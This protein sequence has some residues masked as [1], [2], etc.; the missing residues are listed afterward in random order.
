MA[1][2]YCDKLVIIEGSQFSNFKDIQLH[3]TDGTLDIINEWAEEYPKEIEVLTTI[4]KF[5][6][7]RENQAANFNLALKRCKMGDYFLPFDADDLYFEKSIKKII[8]IT[9][10]GRVDYLKASGPN[11]AFSFDWYLI[12]NDIEYY[13]PQV[14]FKK[15]WRLNFT[16]THT[17][18]NYGK[19][20][21]FDKGG[22]WLN[23][24]KWVKPI[25]RMRLR[26]RTSG[27]FKGMFEWFENNWEKIELY[28]NNV[29]K[30][31]GGEFTLRKYN[32]P[33]P[34]ILDNH[35]WRYIKD[36]RKI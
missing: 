8:E 21:V 26:H 28:D 14:L 9:E 35:P 32:G 15:K 20:V 2:K 10:E 4:R 5:Q 22:D 17:P 13:Y 3:S 18:H 30:Y 34:K 29:V 27:F 7:Y 25:E 36:V 23:H 12:Q 1:M 31:Y 11:L 24:Y 6:N 19:N 33:H 16:R